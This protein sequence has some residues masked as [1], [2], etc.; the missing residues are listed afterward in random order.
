MEIF[1]DSAN[2]D[3]IKEVSSYG[4]LDGITTNPTLIKKEVEKLRKKGKKV[5]IRSYIKKILKTAKGKKVSLEV[6]GTNYEEM[7]KEAQTLY[8]KF[9]PIAKKIYIKI[10]VNPCLEES[11][12]FEADGI[13]SIKFLSLK[14]IPINCTLIFTPEQAFLA[15]IAGAKIVSPF[16]GREDDYL[17]EMAR[18]K[19]KRKDYF[20]VEGIKRL[21]K[22]SNDKGIVS[23]VDLIKKTRELFNLNKIKTQILAASIRNPQQ[24]R[25]VAIAGAD[26]ATMPF[27]V[28]K[29]LFRHHKTAEGMRQFTK[30]VTKE[31]ARLVRGKNKN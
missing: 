7:I 22:I 23:G 12:D 4:I 11:C 16:A 1:I 21:G 8:K 2:V 20:P 30:D 29:E 15:A 28:I 9:Y 18:I 13:K 25:E 6:I 27:Q 24:F 3:E 26:I 5:N 10:P 31:Y 17:R 14:K 19:F